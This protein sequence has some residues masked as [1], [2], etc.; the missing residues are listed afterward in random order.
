MKK[1]SMFFL[2]LALSVFLAA[3]NSDSESSSGAS[4][5]SDTVKIGSLHPLTGS[6]ASEGQEMDDAIKLAVKQVNEQ[7]GIESLGGAKV[8][9]I[10]SDSEGSAE[11]G[12]SEVQK[13]VR[14]GVAGIVGPYTS[15]VA[16]SATQEAEK[17]GVPFILDVASND[18]LTERGFKYTF[19][20]QPSASSMAENFLKHFKTLNENSDEKLET[21]VISHE[22]S[23]F[24]TFFGKFIEKNAE[25]AGL[26]ILDT[27]SHPSDTTNLS[28][29][30]NK[31][32]SLNPDVVIATTYL[33]DG[34]LL[35]ESLNKSGFKPK[36]I[37]GV[38][39]GAFS[40]AKFINEATD[41]N[42]Y[43]LDT[44]YAIN[45]KSEFASKVRDEYKEEFGKELGPNAALSYAS[46]RVL[47]AAIK[48]AGSTDP[49][50]V[51]EALTKTNLKENILA[52]GPIV[53]DKTGQ[54]KNAQAVL[55]QII[56]GESKVVLPKEY[57]E[58]EPVYPLP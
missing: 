2:V 45:P 36:A 15:G 31:I 42:Q 47:L 37:I 22:E 29:D 10:S 58:V 21:A 32:K 49:E 17:Q 8:E 30:I 35:I 48:K 5:D 34:K 11:K 55:N 44:N 26:E 27:L 33:P 46:A 12:I 39:N 1:I 13:M 16:F 54:N 51:R 43:I 50:K 53:F 9:L 7:G 23:S 52:Q 56:D 57:Q 18:E 38:A 3:C 19:R 24:G 6:L 40:N 14:D 4:G 28:S 41:I 25:K 20:I